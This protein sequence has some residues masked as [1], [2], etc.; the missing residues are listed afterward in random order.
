M[1]SIAN[2]SVT[3]QTSSRSVPAPP[4]WFGEVA[5]LVSYLRTQGVLDAISPRGA[6]RDTHLT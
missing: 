1:T 3:I 6:Q 5:L 4:P 2:A